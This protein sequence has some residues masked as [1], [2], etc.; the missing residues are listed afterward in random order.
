M[1]DLDYT[2][3]VQFINFVI[4]LV[5]L[6][7]ILIKPVRGII[8]K[9]ADTMSNLLDGAEEFNAKAEEKLTG[10]AKALDEAR[11]QGTAERN[12][13]KDAGLEQEKEILSAA[14]SKAQAKLGEERKAINEEADTATAAL[15]GQVDAMATKVAGKILA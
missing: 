8:K 12:T 13:V 9:R 15:K 10:Y 5:V 1:I 6:N 3:F 14:S 2:I 7:F 4:T 11:A